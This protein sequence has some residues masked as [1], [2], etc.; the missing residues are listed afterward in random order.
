MILI[1]III[2]VKCTISIIYMIGIIFLDMKTNI[3]LFFINQCTK[4]KYEY[5]KLIL[6]P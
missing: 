3:F 6:I 2:I 4:Y 5:S 1:Y